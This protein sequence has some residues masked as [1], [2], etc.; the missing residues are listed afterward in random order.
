MAGHSVD[1]QDQ[2]IHPG[3]SSGSTLGYYVLI[4]FHWSWVAV[5]YSIWCG[6]AQPTVGINILVMGKEREAKLIQQASLNM[7]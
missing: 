3:I 7:V 6:N 2:F 1:K 4:V 5:W